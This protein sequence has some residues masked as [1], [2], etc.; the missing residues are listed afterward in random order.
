MLQT[1]LN[2]QERRSFLNDFYNRARAMRI[3]EWQPVESR[4]PM[5]AGSVAPHPNCIPRTRDWECL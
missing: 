5:R 1:G 4:E 3:A 2:D